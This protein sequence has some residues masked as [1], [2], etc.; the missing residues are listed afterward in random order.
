MSPNSQATGSVR[1][2]AVI[3][4]EIRALWRRLDGRPVTAAERAEY[5][6]LVVE[7]AGA[8]RVE[9]AVAEAA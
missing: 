4:E 5:A 7:W 3:N 2:A 8:V 6:A 1:P 9:G